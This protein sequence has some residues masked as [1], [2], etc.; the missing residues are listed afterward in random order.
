MISLAPV[1]V[2]EEESGGESIPFD[3]AN[4]NAPN[5]VKGGTDADAAADDSANDSDEG[6]DDV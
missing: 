6:G 4:A 3:D 2:S 5:E 1:E